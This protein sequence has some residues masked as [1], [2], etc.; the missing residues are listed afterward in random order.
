MKRGI[1]MNKY[2]D[3]L[4]I[5]YNRPEYTRISLKRL[6]ETCNKY[7]R[8]WVWHNGKNDE[9]INVINSMRNHPNFFKFHHSTENKKLIIPTNWLWEN[10][11]G[12][13]LSKIDDDCLMPFQWAETLVQAHEDNP[14]FGIIGCWRFPDE[15]FRPKIANRKIISFNNGHKLMQNCWIEGSG[16]LM[17]RECDSF[18]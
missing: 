1:S 4:M 6:L 2:I 16:Y 7:M 13:Y 10:A 17:K 8:V 14:K 12:D 15:D 18:A 11:N 5:T 3:I 9:T